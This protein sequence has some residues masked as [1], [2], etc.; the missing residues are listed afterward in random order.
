MITGYYEIPN[1]TTIDLE[2]HKPIWNFN[3]NDND[4]DNGNS[5]SNDNTPTLI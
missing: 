4:N 1:M 2:Y 3:D 5:N